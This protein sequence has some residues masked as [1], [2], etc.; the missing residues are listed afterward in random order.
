MFQRNLQPHFYHESP[1][2]LSQINPSSVRVE[3][4]VHQKWHQNC[5]W[6][7]GV[8]L[9]KLG[10]DN[11]GL[12]IV[13]YCNQNYLFLSALSFLQYIPKG[14]NISESGSVSVKPKFWKKKLKLKAYVGNTMNQGTQKIKW[15]R[16][17]WKFR[18]YK[19]DWWRRRNARI[20]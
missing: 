9:I 15:A 11:F 10:K 17:I 19:F 3:V 13:A 6:R 18:P 14:T 8:S 12:P 5:S 1:R 20:A 7:H 16:L 4:R 2:N